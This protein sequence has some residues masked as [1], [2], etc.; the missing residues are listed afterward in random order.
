MPVFRPSKVHKRTGD[1]VIA[2]DSVFFTDSLRKLCNFVY[3][4]LGSYPS[5]A[6]KKNIGIF[7]ACI[8]SLIYII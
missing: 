1:A 2:G 6:D 8:I 3:I 7:D 5:A 4:C